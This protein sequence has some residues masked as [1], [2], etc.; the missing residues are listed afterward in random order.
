M[1]K[2]GILGLGA[3]GVWLALAAGGLV[4]Q[5]P[6]V[7]EDVLAAARHEE[8]RLRELVRRCSV[9]F[10]SIGAG[11]GVCI[12]SDG[13]IVTN[14][15]VAGGREEWAVFFGDGRPPLT[16]RRLGADERGDVYLLKVDGDQN[17][18]PCLPLGDAAKLRVGERVMAL[19]NPWL[20]SQDGR[21]TVTFG[22][23][24]AL[25]YN[26]GAYSNAIVTDTPVNP[27]NSGG[28]LINLD[29]EVVGINGRIATRFS[30]QRFNTGMAFAI[31]STQITNFLRTLA[32]DEVT[33]H[34]ALHDVRVYTSTSPR[35]VRVVSIFNTG[36]AYRAGLRYED[37]ITHLSGVAI[38]TEDQ[39]EGL[40]ASY[41]AGSRVRLDVL[42][43]GKPV[44][45]E[46]PLASVE[47]PLTG[48]YLGIQSET[49]PLDET[50][51]P[52][53]HR[54]EPYGPAE[55]AGFEVGDVLTHLDGLAIRTGAQFLRWVRYY[56]P[57]KTLLVAVERG[58]RSLLLPL[59]LAGKPATR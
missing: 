41:P 10:C 52:R 12:R 35:G 55:R 20:L 33:W 45:V 36:P 57:G 6:A 14:D 23:V 13:L 26:Q 53:I 2:R 48:I 15:H 1:K 46:V 4:G 38:T 3:L 49:D 21:P 7:S 37:V 22:V 30:R 44:E 47:W 17:D 24:S 40:L 11:S 19:G 28:P 39:F 43:D 5:A 59:T 16:A 42:R 9:A 25:H 18:L 51:V 31:P 54:L 58:D 50:L 27:G 8:A 34:G 56:Y 29:G 32:G